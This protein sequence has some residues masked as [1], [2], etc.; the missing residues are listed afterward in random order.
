MDEGMIVSSKHPDLVRVRAVKPL[1][2]F[3]V[4]VWFTDGSER[5]INLGPY[6]EGPIFEPIR[7]SPEVFLKIFVDH[8]ALAWPNGADIDTDT[9]YYDGH[10][11]WATEENQKEA[12]QI[13]SR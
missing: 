11:P 7:R 2:G 4:H 8:G 1:H 13:H 10:P 9:L 6:L 5:E 3:N 12:G